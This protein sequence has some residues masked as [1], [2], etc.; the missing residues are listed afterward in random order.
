M[1]GGEHV[2]DEDSIIMRLVRDAREIVI[3]RKIEEIQKINREI[4][5]RYAE[6]EKDKREAESQST[7]VGED[8]PLGQDKD[9][10]NSTTGDGRR[11]DHLQGNDSDDKNHNN[12]GRGGNRR[13]FWSRG[14]R[15]H[16]KQP[17][18]GGQHQRNSDDGHHE[19]HG[20]HKTRAHFH[21]HQRSRGAKFL[22]VSAA[23]SSR[24]VQF[25]N[26]D[27]L[28]IKVDLSQSA[29]AT[30]GQHQSRQNNHHQQQQQKP[31]TNEGEGEH[32]NI[33]R[34]SDNRPQG[35]NGKGSEVRFISTGQS[36]GNKQ[37][38]PPEHKFDHYHHHHYHHHQHPPARGFDH[39]RRGFRP[40]RRNGGG[41]WQKGFLP[42]RD[43]MEARGEEEA[44]RGT[45]GFR[46]PRGGRV[47]RRRGQNPRGK[48][49]GPSN[50]DLEVNTQNKFGNETP[51]AEDLEP[52]SREVPE[53]ET[54]GNSQSV[55][56][57]GNLPE[58]EVGDDGGGSEDIEEDAEAYHDSE[59][60]TLTELNGNPD[61][62]PQTEEKTSKEQG[63]DPSKSFKDETFEIDKN[64]AD[65][66]TS[67][68]TLGGT[69]AKVEEVPEAASTKH[70][71]VDAE[72]APKRSADPAIDASSP[73]K[74]DAS[75]KDPT[76]SGNDQS[77]DPAS[78]A[79]EQKKLPKGDEGSEASASEN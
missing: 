66:F 5:R 51:A 28:L 46:M 25:G 79:E 12:R 27:Q 69:E 18:R 73:S 34:G 68:I 1:R 64:L 4:E 41:R 49:F 26:G 31:S 8:E 36:E 54:E 57:G 21:G 43:F 78:N 75:E 23:S 56:E 13:S 2:N 48:G 40:P 67:A 20:H 29:V 37:E 70:E 42:P 47:F 35:R 58:D 45:R 53:N 32:S 71:T 62:Q 19:E 11:D 65:N 7:H 33:Q 61:G 59:D 9:P 17:H 30:A 60:M 72:V 15:G 16:F 52:V 3:D 55:E 38:F 74:V 76:S 6:V 44:F 10:S 50:R 24:D 14:G 77:Q 39:H 63:Q 22:T